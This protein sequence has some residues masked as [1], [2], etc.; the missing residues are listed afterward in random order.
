ML[1]SPRQLDMNGGAPIET[2]HGPAVLVPLAWLAPGQLA[3]VCA[4]RCRQRIGSGVSVNHVMQEGYRLMGH[5][6]GF[7]QSAA[8]RAL[9]K[10]RKTHGV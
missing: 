1:N 7:S 9:E 2:P 6:R 4:D 8:K 5:E 10:Q 3:R